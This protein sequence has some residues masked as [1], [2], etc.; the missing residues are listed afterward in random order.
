MRPAA[1]SIFGEWSPSKVAAYRASRR[2]VVPPYHQ[3]LSQVGSPKLECHAIPGYHATR[4][5]RR[6]NHVSRSQPAT[7]A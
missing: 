7:L 4:C 5:A 3:G 1:A 6:G 2:G